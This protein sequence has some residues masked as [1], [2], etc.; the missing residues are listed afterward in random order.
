M[1]DDLHM[2]ATQVHEALL[3]RGATVAA[4]ESL[5]GGSL[6]VLLSAAP[7]ASQTFR[8]AIVSYATEV[9]MSLLE[10]PEDVVASRGVVSAECAVAMAEG[11][12]RALD[13]SYALS[14][15]GVAG[16]EPQEGK[17]VGL[18][19]VALADGRRTTVRRLELD[20]SRTEIQQATCREALS[21]L[22][23]TLAHP[24]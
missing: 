8:G 23:T 5:T 19:F 14:T 21:L 12:R 10:V 18:V 24:L 6:S 9:K 3:D 20:G 11:A 7:G 15:T 1:N 13:A 4:A 16:P 2:L 22:A 17:P